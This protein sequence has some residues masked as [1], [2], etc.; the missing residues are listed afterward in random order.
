MLGFWRE[1]RPRGERV[2]AEQKEWLQEYGRLRR[3]AAERTA[4]PGREAEP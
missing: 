4:K 1:Q 2:E 3:L